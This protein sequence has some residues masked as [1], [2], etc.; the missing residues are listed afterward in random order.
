MIN[1]DG[2]FFGQKHDKAGELTF[3]DAIKKYPGDQEG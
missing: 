1:F 2:P 3:C